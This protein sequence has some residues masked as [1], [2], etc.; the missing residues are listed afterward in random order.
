MVSRPVYLGGLGF[1]FKWNMGWMNDTLRYMS[2]DPIHRKYHHNDLTFGL[3]YAFHENFILPLSHDEVVHGKRS[4][5]DKMPGDRWQKFA[6]LRCYFAFFF[7]HP[8]K[9]LLFMGGEIG[10]WREWNHDSSLDWHLL[11]EP[12]HKGLQRLVRDLNGIYRGLPALHERDCEPDGFCWINGADADNN[13]VS[14]LRFAE[15]RNNFV[16]VICNFSP[17]VREG[18]RLGVPRG[19]MYLEVVNTDSEHYAGSNV[20][21]GGFIW[22][23]DDPADH[24]PASLVLTLPPLAALVL[25]P[26]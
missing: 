7:T 17:V 18:Y 5:L 12:D 4:L 23:W 1:G 19:G 14:Y 22:A 6:N 9:K 11:D 10:Q 21:N 2:H 15:D 26:E 8:G 13:V 20:G 3:L 16:I 25:R 24:Q